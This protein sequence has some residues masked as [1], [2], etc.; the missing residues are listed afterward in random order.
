ML[1]VISITLPIFILISLGFASTSLGVTTPADVRALGAFVIRFALPALIFQSLSQRP[2]A[3]IVNAE[4]LVAYTVGSGVVFA[5]M[6]AL[7][8]VSQPGG[9]AANAMSAL[10]SSASNSGF[11]GYPVALMFLG[12]P[13]SFALALNMIT[14]NVVIIPLALTL[15]ESGRHAGK[16]LPQIFVHLV[17]QLVGNPMFIG[18]ALGVAASLSGLK[19]LGPVGKS[20]DM[21]AMTSGA[22]ALFAVGGSLVGLKL[23]GV[24][25]DVGRIV[26]G[27]LI[28]HPVAILAASLIFAPR[29]DPNLRKAMLIFASAPM[30]SIYPLL[31]RQ[32]GQEHVAAASLLVATALSF[33]TMSTLLLA[34]SW[35]AA[36]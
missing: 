36:G 22:L 35:L 31:G 1:D 19:L 2:F 28:L 20:I 32:Y 11:I 16:S 7:A 13:A 15:A 26:A 10:G 21:L 34:L 30:L 12:P 4:Y 17:G 24:L 8:R 25:Q 14:E 5:V 29:L 33:L 3:E 9:V 18:M 27:K 23:G 6:F